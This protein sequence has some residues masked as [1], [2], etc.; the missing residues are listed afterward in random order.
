MRDMFRHFDYDPWEK[1]NW[2]YTLKE[3]YEKIMG[4]YESIVVADK[5]AGKSSKYMVHRGNINSWEIKVFTGPLHYILYFNRQQLDIRID[6][7]MNIPFNHRYNIQQWGL[8]PYEILENIFKEAI[9]QQMSYIP[10]NLNFEDINLNLY[11]NIDILDKTLYLRV[12]LSI[13]D[14][15]SINIENLKILEDKI[16]LIQ[17]TIRDTAKKIEQKCMEERKWKI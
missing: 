11:N 3:N 5:L 10:I 1:G 13:Q 2:G 9:L 8:A 17:S 4:H 15:N 12:I 16:P 14:I 7:K 6:Y